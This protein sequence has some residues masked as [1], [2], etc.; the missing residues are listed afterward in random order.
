[1]SKIA[2]DRSKFKK[3]FHCHTQAFKFLVNHNKSRNL[4]LFY[5]VE[6]GLKYLVLYEYRKNHSEY[7]F[8]ENLFGGDGHDLISGLRHWRQ[9]SRS[10]LGET[11]KH[12][13]IKGFRNLFPFRSIHQAWRY[14]LQLEREDET[15]AV[16][17]LKNLLQ[18][19]EENLV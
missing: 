10:R 13:K 3:A 17:W 16:E 2:V 7:L 4:L 8:E 14:G 6:C 11:P 1:M 9:A 19:I 12:F 18:F 5:A 15:H